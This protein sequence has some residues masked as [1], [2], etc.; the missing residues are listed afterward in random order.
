MQLLSKDAKLLTKGTVN[1]VGLDLYSAS[2][3]VLSPQA[4][5]IIPTDIVIQYPTGTYI[6]VASRS[7][8]VAHGIDCRGRVIDPENR[9]N[10]KVIMRNDTDVPYQV[11]KGS[12]IAQGI[13]EKFESTI[14][15][16]TTALEGT[17]RSQK[18]FGSTTKVD[19]QIKPVI[20][21]V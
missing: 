5:K 6:R 12:K 9:G 1:S 17:Q 2:E 19:D 11:K 10:I 15:I 3:V 14:P 21:V 13:I 16:E 20:K 4:T 8:L 7:S 18:G